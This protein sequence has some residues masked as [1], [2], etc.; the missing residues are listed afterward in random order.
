MGE[1][2]FTTRTMSRK[3]SR[4]LTYRSP[5]N[6]ILRFHLLPHLLHECDV[7]DIFKICTIKSGSNVRFADLQIAGGGQFETRLMRAAAGDQ[8][9]QHAVMQM[10][11]RFS[12]SCR[13]PLLGPFTFKTLLRHCAKQAPHPSHKLTCIL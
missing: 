6:I 13:R 3:P 8:L 10:I 2:R 5:F 7:S 4:L 11:H 12:Q 9:G 1:R